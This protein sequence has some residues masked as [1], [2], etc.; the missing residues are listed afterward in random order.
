MNNPTHKYIQV[1]Q[2]KLDDRQAITL[3]RGLIAFAFCFG[4]FISFSHSSPP[5]SIT[6]NSYAFDGFQVWGAA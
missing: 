4:F 1:T 6:D 3:R 2:K 5:F